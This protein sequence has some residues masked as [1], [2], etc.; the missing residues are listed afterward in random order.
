MKAK[1][2]AAALC[3]LFALPLT[4]T[5]ADDMLGFHDD[6]YVGFSQGTYYGLM[7]ADV[8]YDVAWCMKSQVEHVGA[9]LGAG[10]EFQRALERMLRECRKS[11]AEPE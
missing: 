6:Y 5:I 9:D 11:F 4:L 8:P 7:L 3:L 1:P 2:V 10:A